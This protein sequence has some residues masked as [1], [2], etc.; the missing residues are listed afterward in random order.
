MPALAKQYSLCVAGEG[1]D[2]ITARDA[3]TWSHVH[4]ISVFA[5]MKPEQKVQALPFIYN[6]GRSSIKL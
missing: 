4:L 2:A 6:M 5:R 1:L 3:S